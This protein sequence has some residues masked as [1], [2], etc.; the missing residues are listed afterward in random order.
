LLDIVSDI[1]LNATIPEQELEKERGVILQ[2]IS[3]YED[4]PQRK[5]HDVFTE[6]LHGDTPAG[7]TVLGSVEN[8]KNFKR[9]DF[10]NYKNKHYVASGTIVVV[11][12]NLTKREVE[13]TVKKL[14]KDISTTKKHRKEKIKQ[15]QSSPAVSIFPKKT[16]Q[17]HLV[18][19]FRGFSAKDR[20]SPA[21]GVLAG[22]LGGG[23]SSR[24]FQKLREEMGACYY[25]RTSPNLFSDHGDLTISTGVNK[26]RV[27]EVKEV[28]LS[29]CKRLKTELVSGQ[30]LKKTKDYLIGNLYMDLETTS[31]LATFF[32]VEEISH[33]RLKTAK[34]IEK[35]IKSV[36]A[37]AIQKVACEVFT[38]ANLNLAI[39]GQ[40]PDETTLKKS[41]KL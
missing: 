19:G 30:E 38:S 26:D 28:L 9:S 39:V 20:R 40:A 36:T 3:M 37:K 15:N 7:R 16:D 23:M 14:F 12:G 13:E 24:L 21:L 27:N 18:L 31:A 10:L 41:L 17:T 25:V 4:L 29:E 1:Y 2:E 22:V 6:L 32:A 35:E 8:I 33:G 5:V 34:E 11:A